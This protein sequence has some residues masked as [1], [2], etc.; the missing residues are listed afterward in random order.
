LPPT[1]YACRDNS[2]ESLNK[3][4]A[5][6]LSEQIC[7]VCNKSI[8]NHS[9]HPRCF[10][11]FIDKIKLL[12]SVELVYSKRESWFESKLEKDD[13]DTAFTSPFKIF[14]SGKIIDIIID[15]NNNNKY[16]KIYEFLF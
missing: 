4:L 11:S 5:D 3:E 13:I 2:D 10:A 6:Y 14:K 9:F 8:Q 1:Y 7:T 12:D 16:K 15:Y